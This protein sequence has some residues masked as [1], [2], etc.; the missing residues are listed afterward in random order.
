MAIGQFAYANN[1]NR[2]LAVPELG[3]QPFALCGIPF[4]GAVTN[5][6][7]ARF[8]PQEIRRASL[9]LCDGIHPLFD[10]SPT[11]HLG[12]AGDM[13]LRPRVLEN[14]AHEDPQVR[15]MAVWAAARLFDA[16]ELAALAEIHANESDADVAREWT[17]ALAPQEHA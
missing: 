7:G 3:T 9:M 1:S 15:A 13:R 17:Q 4:D 6:P 11:G 14:L 16:S 12:D 8:G 10:V 2:F 5:R